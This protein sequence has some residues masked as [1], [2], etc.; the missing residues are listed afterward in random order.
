VRPD[1]EDIDDSMAANPEPEDP[2]RDLGYSTPRP[3]PSQ[4][5]AA[6]GSIAEPE[7]ACRLCRDPVGPDDVLVA[8][9]DDIRRNVHP[10][11]A[12]EQNRKRR[13]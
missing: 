8:V 9:G 1:D 6:P 13:G 7:R 12:S 4:R 10:K 11:C 3:P 5:A 2:R